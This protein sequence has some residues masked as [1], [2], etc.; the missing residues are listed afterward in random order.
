MNRLSFFG[1][2]FT[3]ASVTVR[4]LA[5]L[6]LSMNSRVWM[7]DSTFRLNVSGT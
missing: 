2:P 3:T 1:T 4:P 7:S 6:C 5:R